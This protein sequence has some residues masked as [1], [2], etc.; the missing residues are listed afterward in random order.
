[1]TR[2]RP[3]PRP[4][5]IPSRFEFHPVAYRV[6][7]DAPRLVVADHGEAPRR[8]LL[9]DEGRRVAEG[10]PDLWDAQGEAPGESGFEAHRPTRF[11][12]GRE[13]SRRNFFAANPVATTERTTALIVRSSSRRILSSSARCSRVG[14]KKIPGTRVGRPATLGSIGR[15]ASL[16]KRA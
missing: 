7:G 13:C 2:S 3:A 16:V 11:D 1:M 8:N 12:M 15:Q 10:R 9:R 6:E 14:R 4:G 5:D